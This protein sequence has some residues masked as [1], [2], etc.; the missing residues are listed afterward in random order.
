[1]DWVSQCNVILKSDS[2]SEDIVAHFQN[3]PQTSSAIALW[4]VKLDA[5]IAL[6]SDEGVTVE[7]AKGMVYNKNSCCLG[8]FSPLLSTIVVVVFWMDVFHMHLPAL[9]QRVPE[10]AM[11]YIRFRCFILEQA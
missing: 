10:V 11:Q 1:M 8:L 5:L 4:L 6:Q 7:T 3:M 2:T 9:P